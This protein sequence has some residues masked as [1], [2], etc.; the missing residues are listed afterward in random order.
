MI[1]QSWRER[2]LN[3]EGEDKSWSQNDV[4][5]ERVA[6]SDPD[7]HPYAECKGRSSNQEGG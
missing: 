5:E 3:Q 1:E 6:S 2:S 4:V 7:E